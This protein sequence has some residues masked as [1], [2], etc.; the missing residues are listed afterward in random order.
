MKRAIVV[1]VFVA[2]VLQG[3]VAQVTFQQVYIQAGFF[4]K[5]V[6]QTSDGGYIVGG[7]GASLV[8]TDSYGN[9]VWQKNY[10]CGTVNENSVQQTTDGGYVIVGTTNCIGPGH[11]DIFLIKT[12]AFGDTLW[13]KTYGSTED[14]EGWAVLQ[15]ADTGFIIG[16]WGGT[17]NG[18]YYVVKT[19]NIG[20][21]LWEK[22]YG[23]SGPEIANAIIQTSEGGYA[24]TGSTN[25][26]GFT[27]SEVYVIKIDANGNV[28]WSKT[29]GEYLWDWSTDIQQTSDNGYIV[30]GYTHSFS[31]AFDNDIYLIKLD[32]MGNYSWSQTYTNPDNQV[33]TSV[34]QTT[35]GGYIIAG[36][37]NFSSS[38]YQM[39]LIKA[40]AYGILQWTKA[41]NGNTR[42]GSVELT[43]DG[44]YV[45]A[46]IRSS[47]N[48]AC[49]IKTDSL[50]NSGC[51]ESSASFL[52]AYQVSQ[53]TSPA[54]NVILVNSV[55]SNHA[56]VVSS[57]T[58]DST[59]C[60]NFPTDLKKIAV[61]TFSIYPNPTSGTFT[62]QTPLESGDIQ[63][64]N[65]LGEIA[66][67][68][69]LNTK[70]QIL[71]TALAP[72]IYFV[73][74]SSGEKVFIQK[75]VIE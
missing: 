57:G 31:A 40:N 29:I 46:G 41:Y 69:T 7:T 28:Q 23:G 71:N 67:S 4:A 61:Q 47:P 21:I 36:Y 53:I 39:F 45:L 60:L 17:F 30:V 42:A 9:L 63:V 37:S 66:Y 75:V 3:A 72:G 19:D 74:V 25:S 55:V 51:N 43:S 73:K 49:L 33:G 18:H 44:G 70:N 68:T 2:C 64:F 8:K 6:K 38:T 27:E 12:D 22:K 59:L 11:T 15:T 34:K 10:S 56:T 52:D 62:I 58:T 26:F 20:N 32:S 1:L 48:G 65:V 35:D 16:G 54:T 13:T 14:E 5:S 24:I 50:G